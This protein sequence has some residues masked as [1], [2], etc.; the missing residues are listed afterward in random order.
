MRN[1]NRKWLLFFCACMIGAEAAA[2]QEVLDRIVARVEADVILLSEVRALSRY[3][4]LVD[5]KAESDAQIVDR[6]V[7][8]WIVRNEAQTAR[9]PWPIDAEITR[10]VERVQ[11]SF[12]SAEQYAAHRKQCGLNDEDVR[13]M[14]AAQLY[15]TNYLDSRFR[16]S[17][18]IDAKQVEDFYQTAVVA[19]AKAR[20]QTP[21]SLE[22]SREYIQ[23][24]LMQREINE[25]SERWLKE[26]HARLHVEK[27]LD[28]GAK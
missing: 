10:G 6:L 23:Q 22:A 19:R 28:T 16:S 24:A 14:V 11:S 13:R 20:N 4:Q 25:Q 8:Q 7:D 12:G 1:G 26:S 27:F 21:P 15:L 9:F 18:Q 5:G 17:I 3:Q 2:P